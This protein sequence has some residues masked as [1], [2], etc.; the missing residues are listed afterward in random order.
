[1]TTASHHLEFPADAIDYRLLSGAVIPRAIAWVSTRSPAGVDNLA[2]FSFFTVVSIDPPVLAFAPQD[3]DDRP[4]GLKDT[5]ANV[6]DT[7]AFAVNIVD[8]PL[9]EAMNA[10][11]DTTLLRTESEFDHAGVTRAPCEVITPV[12][13]AESP[14]TFECSLR[15]FRPVGGATLI[16]GD[17]V[18]AHVAEAVTTDARLDVRKL[19]AVGRLA[20]GFYVN[21]ADRFSMPRPP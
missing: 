9:A 12:R 17:V 15:D 13:V 21:L 16:T 5:A 19:D 4:D 11:S 1:M 3:R 2:P 7:E 8:E 20:G 6:R 14:V 10:T 18:Y